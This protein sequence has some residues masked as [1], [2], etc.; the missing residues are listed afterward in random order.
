MNIFCSGMHYFSKHFI[1]D[2]HKDDSPIVIS[3]DD[4]ESRDNDDDSTIFKD[5]QEPPIKRRR[6]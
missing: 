1:L 3:S 2:V 6:N 5:L 4:E